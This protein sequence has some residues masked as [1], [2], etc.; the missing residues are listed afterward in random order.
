MMSQYNDAKRKI[1]LNESLKDN[2]NLNQILQNILKEIIK[3]RT[4]SLSFKQDL[5]NESNKIDCD[6]AEEEIELYLR[7][8]KSES[9]DTD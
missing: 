2:E 6:R 3:L 8:R 1:E 5:I 7:K 9:M 4:A